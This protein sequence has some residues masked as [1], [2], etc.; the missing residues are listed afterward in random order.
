MR[1]GSFNRVERIAI[2]ACP[3]WARLGRCL[4]RFIKKAIVTIPE[5]L[6]FDAEA[7]FASKDWPY[8]WKTK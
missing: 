4:V 5:W 8:L 1:A 7:L 3:N 2:V 6:T